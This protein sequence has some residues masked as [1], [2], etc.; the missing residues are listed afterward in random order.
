M[1]ELVAA[2]KAELFSTSE[3]KKALQELE[4][5]QKLKLGTGPRNKRL[6]FRAV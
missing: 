5:G 3:I 2:A 1:S 4:T 6:L